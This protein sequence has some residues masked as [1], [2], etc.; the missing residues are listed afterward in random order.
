MNSNTGVSDN[1]QSDFSYSN[2]SYTI[3]LGFQWKLNKRLVLDAG[4]MMTTYK[5]APKSFVET[6][7]FDQTNTDL[8]KQFGPYNENYKKETLTFGIGLG[9]SIF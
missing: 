1:Y 2:D 3:G 5:D 6:G 4:A 9:Y 8:I 7:K